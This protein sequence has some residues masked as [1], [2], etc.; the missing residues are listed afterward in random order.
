MKKGRIT[1]IVLFSV[2][3]LLLL[4]YFIFSDDKKRYQWF[5]SYEVGSDQPYG[6]LFIKNLL[7]GYRPGGN[8]TFNT[9]KPLGELL[10][11]DDNR[12]NTDYIFIGQSIYLTDPDLDALLDFIDAGND[13]FIASLGI[14]DELI[15]RIYLS[16]CDQEVAFNGKETIS[17]SMNF[18]HKD[19][20]TEGG[21][22]YAFRIVD[23]DEEYVWN[24]FAP[25][26]FC[27]STAL[28]TPLGYMEPNAVNFIRIPYGRGNLFLHSNPLVFTNYFLSKSNKVDYCSRVFSHLNGTHIIWDEYS[29][30][31]FVGNNANIFSSPLYYVLQQPSLK[32]AWWML[33]L[34]ALLY[35]IFTAKR[36]QRTI[37]V[38]EP[39]TNTSLEYV[40]MI[41]S[42]HYQNG[43]HLD[44]ARKKM[45]YF[46]YFIRTRY[47]IHAQT[48]GEEHIRKLA[49]KSK[50]S[51]GEVQTIFDQYRAIESA[52][53]NVDT[54]LSDL[55]YAIENFYRH[56]K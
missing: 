44:M 37:P 12:K 20:Y 43:N 49:E 3:G 34:S 52:F 40:H 50:V 53:Y 55:Y 39:K 7:H 19:L 45:K 36:V 47:G 9:R 32:Y 38:L 11:S 14:P 5:E 10:K 42:L 26:M 56:C 35:I 13:A 8:F 17:V 28:L 27:D 25:E 18:Y 15:R 41:S 29:K 2:L 46:L 23:E 16:E 51:L 30:I 33:L 1:V 6:T 31:P 48:F 21:Y 4:L 54:K 24:A 22:N